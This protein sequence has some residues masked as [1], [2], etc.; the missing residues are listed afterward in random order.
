MSEPHPQTDEPPL[1]PERP[2]IDPH[3]HF[4][5]ILPLPG[6]MHA[7]QRFLLFEALETIRASG[8]N[9]THTVFVECHSMYRKEGPIGLKPVGEVEFVNG[10]AAMSASGSY[11]A[12]RMAERIVGTADLR[13]GP[14]VAAVLEAEMA[15]AGKRFAGIRFPLAFRDAGIFG[16][17]CDRSLRGAMGDPQFRAGARVLAEMGLTLDVWCFEDQLD[18]LIDLAS[19]LPDLTIVLDHIGTPNDHPLDNRAVMRGQKELPHWRSAPMSISS[20]AASAWICRC[21]LA[22]ERT[23]RLRK[24]SLRDGGHTWRPVSRALAPTAACSK[25]IFRLIAHL[26]VMARYGTPSRSS[27][28][29]FR[30]TKKITCSAA[31]LQMCTGSY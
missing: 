16:G 10:I 20:W 13:L 24:R 5:D 6:A 3:L 28:A 2:I 19:A 22:Q 29:R 9:I 23:E 26:A 15:A 21:R 31:R 8:H 1:D 25:A 18:E 12:C 17:P 4:W 14:R 30:R 27:H 7:P 11:G